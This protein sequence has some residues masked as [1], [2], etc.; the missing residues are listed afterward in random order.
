MVGLGGIGQQ[1]V[2]RLKGFEVGRVLYTGHRE[3]PEGM[4]HTVIQIFI[5]FKDACSFQ[6]KL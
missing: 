5:L 3:K 2:K 1:I 4:L 6:E